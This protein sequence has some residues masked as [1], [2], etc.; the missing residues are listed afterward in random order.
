MVT[1]ISACCVS[2]VLGWHRCGLYLVDHKSSNNGITTGEYS[3]SGSHC[4]IIRVL[5]LGTVLHFDSV[6]AIADTYLVFILGATITSQGELSH[7]LPGQCTEGQQKWL[8]QN[9]Y[10]SSHIPPDSR[11]YYII[12]SYYNFFSLQCYK[13]PLHCGTCFSLLHHML[14]CVYVCLQWG[15]K[16]SIL[17]HII[18][19][20]LATEG[21]HV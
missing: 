1:H 2:Q 18:C 3:K 12:C 9:Y 21:N 19:P 10:Y 15:Y 14:V 20:W 8:N 4:W 16:F 13:V 11:I 17:T 7:I 6:A 5:N